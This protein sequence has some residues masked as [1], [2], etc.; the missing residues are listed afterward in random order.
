MSVRY[1]CCDERRRALLAA[2]TT[3]P[4]ISGIDYLEV[5]Q[6]NPTEIDIVLVR[7]L[8]LPLAQLTGANIRITGGV[9]FPAPIVDPVVESLPGAGTVQMY[10]LRVG[11]GQQTDYSTYRLSIVAEAGR[12]DPPAFLDPHLATVEFSFKVDCGSELDCAVPVAEPTPE[13]DDDPALDYLARDWEGFRR[14]MLDRLSVLVPGFRE[15][16][17]V[18]L[19]STVVEALA[20]RWDQ[21]SYRLDWISTESFLDT[22]RSRT[23]LVRHAR[24]VDY[25]PTEGANARAFVSLGCEAGAGA[26]VPDGQMLPAGTPVLP[27]HAD[28]PTVVTAPAYVEWLR[29]STDLPVVFETLADI[30][31]WE[32]RS[33]IDFYTWGDQ[34]CCLPR[35]STTATL[36][37]TS[38][39]AGPLAVDDLL[40]L[41]EVAAPDTGEA[42]DAEIGHRH[43]VRLTSVTKV[44]DEA[45]APTLG[46]LDVTWADA[47]ALPFDL[48]IT[49]RVQNPSGPPV[50]VVCAGARGNVVLAEHGA[51]LPPS[52]AL[53]LMPSDVGSLTPRL[54]PPAPEAGHRWLPRVLAAG[55]PARTASHLPDDLPRRS[56]AELVDVDAAESLPSLTLRDA[57]STWTARP[58]LL[59]TG[60]FGRDFTVETDATGACTLRCGDGIHGIE[61]A[62]GVALG[63][64]GRFGSGIA[65]NVGAGA[66]GHVVVP[67]ARKTWQI[68]E[69][70]NPVHG[71]GGAAAQ[72][73]AEIRSVAPEAFR[74]PQRAV[75]TEDYA[76]AVRRHPEVVNAV[77]D[78]RW[79]GSWQTVVVHV[80]RVGGRPVDREFRARLLAHLETF[81]LAGF[82]VAVRAA[83]T[84]PLDIELNVC[85]DDDE[86][87]S[88]VGQRVRAALTPV[89]PD[90]AL[91][92]FHPDRFTFG[93]PLY[94]SALVAAV[95][96]VPGVQ[97]VT[98]VVFQRFARLPQDELTLG[99]IRPGPA[100]VLE[101]RDDPSFPER[102]RLRIR[103][104]G[105]R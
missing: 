14:V 37:D 103:M 79:T 58:D 7:P 102:G 104:G 77:A 20:Y 72:R 64:E 16:D 17:P 54:R 75:T 43:I 62:V 8:P 34:E 67:M 29:S 47:D 15:D 81:R 98:P 23:S 31:L 68:R 80:D 97:S 73:A 39:G 5:R 91:G 99:V 22:A 38:G 94:L 3:T 65:G 60:P 32:W 51:S 87:A 105:G 21:Q 84:V 63:V 50:R 13:P 61:P 40:L 18:D 45:L 66:L 78:T 9:R 74:T 2:A 11:G 82:D 10:R 35:G 25:R 4:A 19:L 1:T 88:L 30:A 101:L 57:F 96:A 95:M 59:A 44:Q 76:W 56:A 42:A 28:L 52:A 36:V 93:T 69:V 24:L 100:E 85:A 33:H 92:F 27:R 48:V 12:D 71:G 41:E 49:S 46:L 83:S 26:T 53:E 86:I 89:G 6:G 55:P 70:T 90:G